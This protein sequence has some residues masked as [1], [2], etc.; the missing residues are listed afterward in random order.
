MTVFFPAINSSTEAKQ[1][2]QEVTALRRL[3]DVRLDHIVIETQLLSD[4]VTL[5]IAYSD[6]VVEF[7]DRTTLQNLPLDELPDKATGL[8]QLGFK[9]GTVEPCKLKIQRS[10]HTRVAHLW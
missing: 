10:M 8:P 2:K 4:N 1:L 9:F 5:Q 6:G 7:R 3:G